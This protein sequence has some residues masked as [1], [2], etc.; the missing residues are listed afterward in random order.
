MTDYEH[1]VHERFLRL[2][3]RIQYMYLDAAP[4]GG[5]CVHVPCGG[6]I[7]RSR[8]CLGATTRVEWCSAASNTRCIAAKAMCCKVRSCTGYAY[9][10]CIATGSATL[11]KS[12]TM[13]A[14]HEPNFSKLVV[15]LN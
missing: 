3:W 2:R 9:Y 7:Y 1:V 12:D 11:V 14:W 8:D 10:Y 5:W 15:F 4:T 6:A 13:V